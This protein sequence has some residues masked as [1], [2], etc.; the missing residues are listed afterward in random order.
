[1][2]HDNIEDIFKKHFSDYSIIQNKANHYRV[3]DHNKLYN[4]DVS[5]DKDNI[6]VDFEKIDINNNTLRN[7][8]LRIEDFVSDLN[9]RNKTKKTIITITIKDETYYN[10]SIDRILLN[11]KP[12]FYQFNYNSVFDEQK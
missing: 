1:M 4:F 10:K 2:I 8:L 9:L 5:V 7:I 6:K 12:I 3:S 11:K